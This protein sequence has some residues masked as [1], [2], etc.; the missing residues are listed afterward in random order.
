MLAHLL[1]SVQGRAVLRRW[2]HL[3][4]WTELFEVPVYM[5]LLAPAGSS[6]AVVSSL[7]ASAL[8]HPAAYAVYTLSCTLHTPAG[9]DHL[10]WIDRNVGDTVRWLLV[11]WMVISVEASWLQLR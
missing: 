3:F 1:G 5:L 7:G 11:E 9:W 4:L 10:E 8:S 2:S 6:F